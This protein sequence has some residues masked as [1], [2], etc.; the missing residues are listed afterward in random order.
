MTDAT[1]PRRRTGR[2]IA[3]LVVVVVLLA[4]AV[5]AAEFIARSVVTSTVRSLVVK[6]VGLPDDQN[7]DVSVSGL[8][9][10]QLLGGRLDEVAVSSNDVTLGPITGDVRVDLRGVP[11]SGDAA[12]DGGVASVRLDQDHLKTLLA[13]VP[14]LPA[15]T[16]TMAAPDVNLETSLSLFG[17]AI[18]VGVGV[19]PGAAE[20]DLTLTPSSFQV[21]GNAIDADT[22]RGQFGSV[23]DSLLKTT[24]LCIADRLPRGLTLTSATVQGQDLVAT[25]DVAGGILNDPALQSD[26]ACG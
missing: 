13:E 10:P 3:V 21:G 18:P 23:A 16:V 26:G 6:N 22:L 20:G 24:S 4:G 15:S 8:V 1:A 5:V 17:I 14:D 2:W 7:V 25:F 19:T 12:A 11:V 9:L